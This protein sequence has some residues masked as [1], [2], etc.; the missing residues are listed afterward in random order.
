MT[1]I[2]IILFFA[3]SLLWNASVAKDAIKNSFSFE[4]PPT[5]EQFWKIVSSNKGMV[6][7]DQNCFVDG[8]SSWCLTGYDE[9]FHTYVFNYLYVPVEANRIE[10]SIYSKS[11]LLTN[12]WLKLYCL[13]IDE[14]ILRKDSVSIVNQ[15]DWKNLFIQSGAPGTKRLYIEI[16]AQSEGNS[17]Q[18]QQLLI[19]NLSLRINSIDFLDI[20]RSVD[21]KPTETTSEGISDSLIIESIPMIRDFQKPKIIALGESV[22]GSDNI[23]CCA[24]ETIKYL[25]EHENCKL[26][27]LE[28][29]FELGMWLNEYVLGLTSE[30][31]IKK[32]MVFYNYNYFRLIDLL[33]WIRNYNLTH[34]KKVVVGGFDEG[35]IYEAILGFDHLL[36]LIKNQKIEPDSIKPF[37][38]S[39]ANH[40]YERAKQFVKGNRFFLELGEL[41]LNSFIR[42]LE[43]RE[44]KSNPFLSLVDGSRENIQFLNARYAIDS[45]LKD[46]DKAVIYA[47]LGHVNKTNNL[48]IGRIN[49]PSLG[50]YLHQNYKEEYFVTGLFVGYGAIFNS[51]SDGYNRQLPLVPPVP[52]SIEEFCDHWN[53][54]FLYN[55]TYELK[56]VY[57]GRVL[58]LSYSKDQ[59][60][61][62]SPKNRVDAIIYMKYSKGY[63]AYPTDWPKT[64][65]ETKE[66]INKQRVLNGR[67]KWF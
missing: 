32:R 66:Y 33:N 41:K 62:Y 49:V 23:Q 7:Y 67:D 16:E 59:F 4:I 45:I 48:G 24:F 53:R 15:G 1:K 55:R 8:N 20:I 10:L 21:V 3:F 14:N 54:P 17:K 6:K 12:A 64:M 57:C 9:G 13:D 34:N 31:N 18:Q 40:D 37:F 5:Q 27:L 2:I 61:P 58:G 63:T 29:N 39:Y 30:E 51:G 38:D 60:Y 36:D 50:Y 28:I 11:T 46:S 47:H 42:A 43:L 44:K 35:L 19:D 52:G 25:I 56:S 65:E 22:H 26:V